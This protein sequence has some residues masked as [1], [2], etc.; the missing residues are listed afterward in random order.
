MIASLSGK[1]RLYKVVY[2]S[3]MIVIYQEVR[4]GGLPHPSNIDVGDP[5]NR[6]SELARVSPQ[7]RKK[8]NTQ[9]SARLPIAFFKKRFLG[10]ESWHHRKR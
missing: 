1:L 3:W 10:K 7:R 6:V 5:Y 4:D 8:S 9:R 2:Y